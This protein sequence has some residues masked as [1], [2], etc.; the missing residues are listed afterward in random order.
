MDWCVVEKKD[1]QETMLVSM[2]YVEVWCGAVL[3]GVVR[4]GE[5]R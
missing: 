2:R 1:I 3:C 4:S 5:V